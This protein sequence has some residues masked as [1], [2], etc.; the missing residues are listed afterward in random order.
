MSLQAFCPLISSFKI[1]LN[2]SPDFYTYFLLKE[3]ILI[4]FLSYS[5]LQCTSLLRFP[6]LQ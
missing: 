1:L 2:Y 3:K 5:T 6:L 4:S